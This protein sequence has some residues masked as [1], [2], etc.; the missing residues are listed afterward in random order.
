MQGVWCTESM[1]ELQEEPLGRS[2]RASSQAEKPLLCLALEGLAPAADMD[3]VGSCL[4][5]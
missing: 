1:G 3:G 4:Q 2:P 5:L